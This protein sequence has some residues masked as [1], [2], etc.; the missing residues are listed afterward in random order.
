M[1]EKIIETTILL[2]RGLSQTWEEK[3]PVLAYGEPGY[4][5][6]TNRLKIGDGTTAWNNLPYVLA[7][8]DALVFKGTLGETGTVISL[9][10]NNYKAGWTYKVVESKMWAG[11]YCEVGDMIIATQDGPSSGS[12]VIAEDWAKVQANVDIFTGATASASGTSGLVKAPNAGDQE[13]Y[14]KGNGT[15]STID[16]SGKEDTINKVTAITSNSTDTEY[17]SA[18]AVYTLF[19][20]IVNANEVSY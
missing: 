15:W 17:P 3:N 20:S 4:E 8:A 13:K 18:K 2:R 19:N 10:T 12:T 9:P 16:I 11:E 7:T 6:D 1:A 5:K 14:L